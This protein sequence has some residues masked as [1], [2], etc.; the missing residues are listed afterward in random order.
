MRRIRLIGGVL[1]LRYLS[2]LLIS[3]LL[4]AVFVGACL[5]YLMFTILAEDLGIPEV[6]AKHLFPVMNKINIIL[7]AGF[8]PMVIILIMWGFAL[9][10]RLAGPIARVEREVAQIVKGEYS[11][12]IKVRKKDDLKSIADGINILLDKIQELQKRRG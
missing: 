2:L 5:Y 3:T 9:S 7:V 4:P 1:H 6:I 12:R 11:K 8:I 10:S